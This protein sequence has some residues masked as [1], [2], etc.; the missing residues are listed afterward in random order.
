LP[1]EGMPLVEGETI[2][3]S[4]QESATDQPMIP[5]PHPQVLRDVRPGDRALLGC[6]SC[7]CWIATASRFVPGS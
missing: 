7:R 6:S 2:L 3:L 1:A 4:D 5:L